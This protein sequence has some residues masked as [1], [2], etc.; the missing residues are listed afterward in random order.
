MIYASVSTAIGEIKR[1]KKKPESSGGTDKI[2]IVVLNK[3]MKVLTV[4]LSRCDMLMG[5]EN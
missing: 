2:C 1:K 5:L 4:Q 3:Q